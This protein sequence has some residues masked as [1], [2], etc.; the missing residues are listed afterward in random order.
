MQ[1]GRSRDKKLALTLKQERNQMFSPSIG[2]KSRQLA[3]KMGEQILVKQ[4][5]G[6]TANLD[7][8]YAIPKDASRDTLYK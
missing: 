5:N 3:E 6:K 4:D 7:F 8:F 1:S 2:K